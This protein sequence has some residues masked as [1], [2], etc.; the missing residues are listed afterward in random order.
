MKI[1]FLAEAG[2]QL[3]SALS[4]PVRGGTKYAKVALSLLQY[5]DGSFSV[6]SASRDLL[7]PEELE[8]TLARIAQK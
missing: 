7:K 6:V 2:K 3:P 4:G 5:P 1:A 8:R